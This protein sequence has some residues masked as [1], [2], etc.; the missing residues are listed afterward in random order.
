MACVWGRV[1]RLGWGGGGGGGEEGDGGA[2]G[3]WVR[4]RGGGGG[5]R[6]VRSAGMSAGMEC[7]DECRDGVRCG[8]VRG[9]RLMPVSA[10]ECCGLAFIPE[11]YPRVHPRL[12]YTFDTSEDDARFHI[13]DTHLVERQETDSV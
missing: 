2:G 9:T 7:R 5:R 1:R 13:R 4:V 3:G 12:L 6:A 11:F 8:W 10:F